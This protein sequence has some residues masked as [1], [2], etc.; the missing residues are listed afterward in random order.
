MNEAINHRDNVITGTIQIKLVLFKNIYIWPK[1][2][3]Y[4]HIWAYVFGYNSAIFGPIGLT[5]FRTT[6]GGKMGVATTRAPYGM[7][8]PNPI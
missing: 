6:F 8:P 3:A 7:G 1:K 2:G 4:A 5:I